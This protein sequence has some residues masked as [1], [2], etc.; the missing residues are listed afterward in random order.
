LNFL[1][2]D[3]MHDT[4]AEINGDEVGAFL[5]PAT[6]PTAGEWSELELLTPLPAAGF[7]ESGF[8]RP[9]ELECLFPLIVCFSLKLSGGAHDKN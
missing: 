7:L 8:C 3:M 9:F 4:I 5:P 1:D 6:L 2:E